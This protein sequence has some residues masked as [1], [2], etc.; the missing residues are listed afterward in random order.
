MLSSEAIA[1]QVKTFDLST[2]DG[3][4]GFKLIGESNFDL[5]GRSVS[6]VGDFN[7]DTID[8]II[9]GAYAADVENAGVTIEDAGKVYVV[10]GNNDTASVF[11]GTFNV[12]DLDETSSGYFI[13][14]QTENGHFGSCI[15]AIGDING[16]GIS[17]VAIGAYNAF[18]GSAIRGGLVYVILGM[19]NPSESGLSVTGFTAPNKLFASNKAGAGVGLSISGGHDIDGDGSN[20]LVIGAPMGDDVGLVD[21]GV[22]YVISGAD[23]PFLPYNNVLETLSDNF[24]ITIRGSTVGAFTGA[25]LATGNFTGDKY[26]DIMIGAYGLG[27]LLSG[28]YYLFF[29]RLGGQSF[30]NLDYL[31]GKEIYLIQGEATSE[32]M[33]ISASNAGDLD[34]DKIDDMIVGSFNYP[35]TTSPQAGGATVIYG[36]SQSFFSSSLIDDVISQTSKGSYRLV[37]FDERE[38]DAVSVSGVGDFNADGFGDVIIGAYAAGSNNGRV[39]IVTRQLKPC[40]DGLVYVELFASCSDRCL[41]SGVWSDYETAR[42]QPCH[43]I[44]SGCTG[45]AET[46]C[47]SCK[48]PYYYN[49]ASRIL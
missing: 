29:G 44:C 42:C 17:D 22:V 26:G 25:S 21:S 3:T 2:L 12:A 48:F 6:G 30:Y 10:L 37:G 5:L 27:D 23:L 34:G 19:P 47:Y 1:G 40:A 8:D 15:A 16:D 49:P 4:N 20:D 28:G 39:Y 14:G 7:D 41:T 33:G 38:F 24:T 18:Y 35:L 9:I 31:L 45:P 43:E 32:H 13:S 11:G 36:T 46:D